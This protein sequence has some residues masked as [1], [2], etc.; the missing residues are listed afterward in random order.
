MVDYIYNFLLNL[1][2]VKAC[3][4]FARW[5]RLAHFTSILKYM[6][7]VLR[8]AIIIHIMALHCTL[9]L[10][11]LLAVL[12]A[13][14]LIHFLLKIICGICGIMVVQ[15]CISV[16]PLRLDATLQRHDG[17]MQNEYLEITDTNN[18]KWKGHIRSV[19]N[20]VDERRGDSYLMTLIKGRSA[21]RRALWVMHTT[22]GDRLLMRKYNP[23]AQQKNMQQNAMISI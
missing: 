11:Y 18:L 8:P 5:L 16:S 10:V 1:E 12:W 2:V 13:V 14:S 4:G 20:L 6:L 21:L 17:K 3:I 9:I 19:T 22:E 23:A 15:L 7:D